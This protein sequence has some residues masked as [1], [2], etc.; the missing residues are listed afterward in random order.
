ML[1]SGFH[2][3]WRGCHMV[4]PRDSN[5]NNQKEL[6][7]FRSA[8]NN[9][10]RFPDTHSSFMWS[11]AAVLLMLF[12]ALATPTRAQL[13]VTTAA[14]GGT[15]EDSTGAVIPN[16]AVKLTS[17]ERGVARTTTTNAAGR[18]TFSL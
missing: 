11:A 7:H 13:A 5:D 8:A 10:L 3:A 17:N 12:T 2:L 14:I 1:C 4:V 15:V 16:A 18:Y 6:F 9:K